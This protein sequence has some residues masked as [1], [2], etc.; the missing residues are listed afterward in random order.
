MA[1]D[2]KFI[3][4]TGL[5]TVFDIMNERDKE[6]LRQARIQIGSVMG[7]VSTHS[8]QI[9]THSSQI[10]TLQTAVSNQSGEI[11]KSTNL[12]E[13]CFFAKLIETDEVPTPVPLGTNK[14]TIKNASGTS[15]GMIVYRED[16]KRFFYMVESGENVG[17]YPTW[18]RCEKY[19]EV[20]T[21]ASP[22]IKPAEGRLYLK[23]LDELEFVSFDSEGEA[24]RVYLSEY[25][26]DAPTPMTEIQIRTLAAN[27]GLN[28]D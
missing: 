5:E 21:S 10:S 13:G 25:L 1:E 14:W 4:E 26:P 8:S 17:C 19:G 28:T 3:D 27:Y 24:S 16:K 7:S 9:S 20:G 22:G 18:A 23:L 2:K 6:V 15:G 11:E 12:P